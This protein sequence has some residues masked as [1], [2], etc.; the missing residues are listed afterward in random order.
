MSIEISNESDMSINDID[1]VSVSQFALNYMHV[2]PAAELAITLVDESAMTAL[3]I[4][5]MDLPGPTDVLSFPMDEIRPGQ[6]PSA[7]A[8]EPAMLGD[9]VLCPSVALTQAKQAGHPFEHELAIL[10]VHGC[11]HLLGYDHITAEEEKEMFSLQNTIVLQWY[12]QIASQRNT[13]E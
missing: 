8:P 13:P 2:N 3:H 9:I 6:H 11:L 7:Q 4:Q 12:D 1:L 5:W 10:T